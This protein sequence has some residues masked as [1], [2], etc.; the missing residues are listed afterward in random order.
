M[1]TVFKF[2][3][4][5]FLALFIISCR[6]EAISQVAEV[7]SS[8]PSNTITYKEMASM[9]HQYDVGQKPVLDK[10][11]KELT[12]DANEIE[13]ISHFYDI[14]QLKQYIAYVERLSK[15]KDIKLTGIRI[16]SASY[17]KDYPEELLRGR[18]TLIFMPTADTKE[19]K[20]VAYEPL[21]SNKGE[22]IPFTK[23]LDQFS[24]KETKNVARA[25]FLPFIGANEDLK[26]SGAN[27]LKPT[28][29]M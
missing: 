7:D 18:Q 10:Y 25:S 1:K 2:Y 15:E 29:P 14:N 4:I 26:S 17:P 6:S 13:S 12:G 16:F 24:S 8:R 21:Y 22:A 23:F 9:F 28:P 11:R 3:Q 19:K 27:K 5:F 20:N